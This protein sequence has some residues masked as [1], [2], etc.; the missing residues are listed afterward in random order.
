M[1]YTNL[2]L[3]TKNDHVSFINTLNVKKTKKLVK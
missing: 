2:Y 3:D 1:C